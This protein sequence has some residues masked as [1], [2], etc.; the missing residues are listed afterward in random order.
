M[1]VPAMLKSNFILK[2]QL[3]KLNAATLLMQKDALANSM[4]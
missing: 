2:N 4:E 3:V 1:A